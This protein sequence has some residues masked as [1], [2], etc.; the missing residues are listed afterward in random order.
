[1]SL[2]EMTHPAIETGLKVEVLWYDM[3]KEMWK[4]LFLCV[5]L[6]KHLA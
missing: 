5:I 3:K 6:R 2:R 1:M 4:D